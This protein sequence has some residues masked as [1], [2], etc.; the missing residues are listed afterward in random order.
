VNLTLTISYLQGMSCLN[1][2]YLCA[3]LSTKTEENKL[4][5][6]INKGIS[7]FSKILGQPKQIV[8]VTHINPDGDAIGSTMGMYHY[9]TA[10]GHSVSVIT[11]NDFPDFLA[12]INDSEK[13][14]VF[15]KNQKKAKEVIKNAAIIICI[16]FNDFRRLKDLGPLL[17]ESRAIK[18]LIDHHPNPDT[19]FDYSI[20]TTKASAAAE[21]VYQFITIAGDRKLI[22]SVIAECLY[23]GIMADTGCFSYN[24]LNPETF[25]SVADL[26]TCDIDRDKVYNLVY[27]NFTESRMRLMGYSLNEKMITLPKYHAAYIALTQDDMERYHFRTGDSEGF[28]NLPLS[29]KDIHITALFT[30]KNDHVR[31]SLRSRGGFAVNTICSKYFDGG[32]HKN[33]AGGELKASLKETIEIF[34]KLLETNYDEIK[35]CYNSH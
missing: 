25:V 3:S 35:K 15:Q 34:E 24:I 16:D 33:A 22:N 30:E 28:V 23:A 13:I 12:W 27:D 8:L 20:H 9:L 2:I 7:E 11:P 17:S 31:I 5:Q 6:S 14:I 19:V 1:F 32:G 21:L 26:M 29:I 4:E 10:K 18:G